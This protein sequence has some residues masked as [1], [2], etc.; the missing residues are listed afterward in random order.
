MRSTPAFDIFLDKYDAKYL[1]MPRN[2]WRR[3]GR[4]FLGFYDFPAEHRKHVRTTNPIG[5]SLRHRGTTGPA[6]AMSASRWSSSSSG[7]PSVTGVC[8][9]DSSSS[10]KSS[11]ANAS[12]AVSSTPLVGTPLGLLRAALGPNFHAYFFMLALNELCAS[13][14]KA[15]DESCAGAGH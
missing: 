13:D 2:A 7:T 5:V 14:F 8:S 15:I 10:R 6:A 11:P 4:S 12:T 9:T 1:P 3:T